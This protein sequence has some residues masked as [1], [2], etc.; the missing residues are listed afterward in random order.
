MDQD[1]QTLLEAAKKAMDA[2]ANGSCYTTWHRAL[3]DLRAAIAREEA[4]P[5]AALDALA[6]AKK[7]NDRA[8]TAESTARWHRD[9]SERLSIAERAEKAEAESAR[10]SAELAKEREA[11]AA[12]YFDVRKRAKGAK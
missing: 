2:H 8:Q 4:K 12:P 1:K 7:A 3:A 11:C 10:L 6:D 9:E 5:F